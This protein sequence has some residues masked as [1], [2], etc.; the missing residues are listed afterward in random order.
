MPRTSLGFHTMTLSLNLNCWDYSQL[1][2]DFTEYSHDTGLIRIYHVDG[3]GKYSEY[4]HSS[5]DSPTPINLR[6]SYYQDD[7]GIKWLMRNN[8]LN[9]GSKSYVVEA[10]INPKILGGI[11]DYITAATFDDMPAAIANFNHIAQSIS[12]LLESFDHYRLK[13]VDYC[14][15]FDLNE[16]AP[17]CDPELIM[18]LIKRSNIPTYYTEWTEYDEKAHRTKSRLS[19]FYLINPSVVIN[20]YSKYMQ[21]LEKSRKNI[22][23][24]LPPVA[25][26][27]LDAARYII[28]FEVQC[29]YHK[30]FISSRKAEEAGNHNYNKYESLLSH[31]T[32]DD[33]IR[34]YFGETIGKYD[35]YALNYA[36]CMVQSHRFNKQKE[37]RLVNALRFVNECRSLAKAK[38]DAA[39]HGYDLDAFKRTLKDLSSDCS[40]N[41]VT[42][43][44]E[45]GIRHIPNLLYTYYYK[46]Q[47]ERIEEQERKKM[48]TLD[49]NEYLERANIWT[50]IATVCK[51]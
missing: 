45:W 44:K 32:C 8:T 51:Q 5:D 9:Q 14:I 4:H 7:K 11:H 18:K 36:V 23:R 24:G 42:I 13:R 35:W 39:N 40:I 21:L 31:E 26:A 30:M 19:S 34:Y 3:R 17:G 43:P 50:D 48:M 2:N 12:S 28:R 49:T 6:I 33:I 22:E 15:N 38:K 20:C 10:T 46:V 29:K 27:T 1:I 16:L 25:Q 47:E 41:P 37:D